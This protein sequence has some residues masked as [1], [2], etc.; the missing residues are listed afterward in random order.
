MEDPGTHF[1]GWSD[2]GAPAINTLQA[3]QRNKLESIY[4]SSG[5]QTLG[6]IQIQ[7]ACLSWPERQ[8]TASC[9]HWSL[10]GS[11]CPHQGPRGTGV[12]PGSWYPLAY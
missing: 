7:Q 2:P 8:V 6:P 11:S 1:A 12:G 3:Y 10:H 5:L 4:S 9:Y